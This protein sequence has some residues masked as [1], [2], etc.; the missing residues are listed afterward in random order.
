MAGAVA[1]HG[2]GIAMGEAIAGAARMRRPIRSQ[3]KKAPAGCR[4]F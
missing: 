1:A 3:Y 4:G 2:G